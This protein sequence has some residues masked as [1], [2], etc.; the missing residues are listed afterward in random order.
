MLPFATTAEISHA[1]SLPVLTKHSSSSVLIAALC[2]VD[3]QEEWN[4]KHKDKASAASME[5]VQHFGESF[6]KIQEATGVLP[7]P[8]PPPSQPH[9]RLLAHCSCPLSLIGAWCCAAPFSPRPQ[10]LYIGS[11]QREAWVNYELLLNN[12]YCHSLFFSCAAAQLALPCV[13]RRPVA[14]LRFVLLGHISP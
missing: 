12:A 1:P 4:L 10:A 7:P 3:V 6:A 13:L 2:V 11:S 8:L 9:P 14:L 5:R